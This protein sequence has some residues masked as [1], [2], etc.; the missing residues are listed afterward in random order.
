MHIIVVDSVS[1]TQ[2]MESVHS[3][4]G[5]RGDVVASAAYRRHAFHSC[6][7]VNSQWIVLAFAPLRQSH[8]DSV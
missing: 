5:C 8:T 3:P 6:L 4:S 1:L 7:D 2:V